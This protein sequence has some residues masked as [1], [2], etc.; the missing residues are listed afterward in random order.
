MSNLQLLPQGSISSNSMFYYKDTTTNEYDHRIKHTHEYEKR[1]QIRHDILPHKRP[2]CSHKEIES[3]DNNA[4]DKACVESINSE[5]YLSTKYQREQD[6]LRT[7]EGIVKKRGQSIRDNFVKE[8]QE[9]QETLTRIIRDTL[10]FTKENTPMISMLPTKVADTLNR[11]EEYRRTTSALNLSNNSINSRISGVSASSIKKYESCKFLKDLGLDLTN[12]TPNNIKIDID[13]AYEFIKKW[14]IARSDIN[15]VIRIKLVNEIM[16]VE[17]RRSV[18]RVKKLKSKMADYERRLSSKKN[19]YIN[20][21]EEKVSRSNSRTK[22]IDVL[23]THGDNN[24]H[25]EISAKVLKEANRDVV[26][27]DKPESRKVSKKKQ[28]VKPVEKRSKSK[29]RRSLYVN[30]NRRSKYIPQEPAPKKIFVNLSPAQT[31][32][33]TMRSSYGE[34]PFSFR[35]TSSTSAKKTKRVKVNGYKN[36]QKVVKIINSSNELLKNE[37]IRQHYSNLLYNKKMEDLTNK[38][39][40]ENRLE[41]FESALTEN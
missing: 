11:Y 12:L 13:K 15:H 10:K 6:N 27:A 5:E 20:S 38:I 31:K 3:K 33:T 19:I 36:I 22:S 24:H 2:H 35:R 32:S 37:N 18:H 4:F 1:Y 16:N 17:E 14:N 7:I 9:L 26:T 23:G 30:P 25:T 39:L 8:K 29:D 34:I 21:D 41:H 40:L 28:N